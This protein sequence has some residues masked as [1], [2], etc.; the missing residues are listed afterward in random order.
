MGNLCPCFFQ[1][2]APR[3][4]D[5]HN[6]IEAIEVT[7]KPEATFSQEEKETKSLELKDAGNKEFKQN[8]FKEAIKLYSDAI[9]TFS[10][11]CIHRGLPILSSLVCLSFVFCENFVDFPFMELSRT[12]GSNWM[13]F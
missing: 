2:R 4:R 8:N 1:K 7:R 10:F 11:V 12:W 6:Y 3:D 5:A 13:F 9:V